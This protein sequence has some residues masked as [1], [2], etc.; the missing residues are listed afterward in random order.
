VEAG[1]AGKHLGRPNPVPGHVALVGRGRRRIGAG[2]APYQGTGRIENLE[3]QGA[4]RGLAKPVAEERALGRVLPR[5]LL[6]REGRVGVLVPADPGRDLGSEEVQPGDRLHVDLR[7]L[8]PKSPDRDLDLRLILE[9]TDHSRVLDETMPLVAQYPT[10]RWRAG[11]IVRGQYLLNLSA[12]TP[13]GPA[14]LRAQVIA[15]DSQQV[16]QEETLGTVQVKDRPR[17]FQASPRFPREDAFGG[18]VRLIGFDQPASTMG[19]TNEDVSINTAHGG[20]GDTLNLTLYWQAVDEMAISYK[21][22]VQL[23]DPSGRL[24]AQHDAPPRDGQMP[25]TGWQ[26]N[27]VVTELLAG[28]PA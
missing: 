2:V 8:S 7:W 6:G 16:L 26:I 15:H 1:R 9:G 10:S 12:R 5:G 25:T 20:P 23:L 22:F 28:R 17:V 18:R 24:V 14:T 13:T 21:V 4:T 19:M 3:P 27:E 11:E